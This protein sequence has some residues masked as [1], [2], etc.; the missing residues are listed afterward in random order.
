MAVAFPSR[1]LTQR[2]A[3]LKAAVR[4]QLAFASALHKGALVSD[5]AQMQAAHCT[6]FWH[7]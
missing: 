7:T 4:A 1:P 5:S 6:G 3:L 2:S